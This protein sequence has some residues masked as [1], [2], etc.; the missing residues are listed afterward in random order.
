MYRKRFISVC[1][2]AALLQSAACEEMD[3]FSD[4]SGYTVDESKETLFFDNTQKWEPR[5]IAH[6]TKKVKYLP[7]NWRSLIAAAV[8]PK[9]SSPRTRAE[10]VYLLEIQEKRTPEDI[11]RIKS[12]I[13]LT[14]FR[15][16]EFTYPGITDP[17]KR[18]ATAA[19]ARA[20]NA[21]ITAVMFQAKQHFNRVRPS[22]LDPRIQPAI[23][24]PNHPAYPSGHATQAF[25]WAYLL[26]ELLPPDHHAAIL[27]GAKRIARDR[28]LA[29][30][31]YPSDSSLGK[32]IARQIVDMWM[33]NPQFRELLNRAKQEW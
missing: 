13:K 16:G 25:M 17:E 31:H 9:N 10:L 28:E 24:I 23:P 29:G 18:P 21:D 3:P 1:Y 26:C 12:E 15:F 4:L 30:V 20:A 2:L 27:A 6:T 32:Q 11:E 33:A 22:M 7:G 8:P 5:Y 19:L 14:G